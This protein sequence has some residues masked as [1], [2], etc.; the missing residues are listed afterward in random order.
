MT[1]GERD[2]IVKDYQNDMLPTTSP[3]PLRSDAVILAGGLSEAA[4]MIN[5][6]RMPGLKE[7]EATADH[8]AV[9]RYFG[10]EELED[11]WASERP[12]LYKTLA[13]QNPGWA[14]A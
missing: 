14:R 9:A 11:K 12:Q 7:F 8:V 13:V 2:S 10:A 4:G 1:P 5:W 3:T 6:A